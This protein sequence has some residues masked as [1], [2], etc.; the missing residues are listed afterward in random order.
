METIK[1]LET[2]PLFKE[3]DLTGLIDKNNINKSI[4]SITKK[5]ELASRDINI[6]YYL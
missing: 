6:L 3:L 5:Y 2:D 1:Q 4:D